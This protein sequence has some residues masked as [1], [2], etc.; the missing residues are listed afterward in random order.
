VAGMLVYPM[1]ESKINQK[2][3]GYTGNQTTYLKRK[4]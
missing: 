3:T 4:K 2:F 1:E